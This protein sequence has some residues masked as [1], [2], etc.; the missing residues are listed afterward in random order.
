VECTL[1]C[2]GCWCRGRC[3]RALPPDEQPRLDR[4]FSL[5]LDDAAPLEVEFARK[6]IPGLTSD[7]K[8]PRDPGR[9]HPARGVHG[10]APHVVDELLEPDDARDGRTDVHSD[11]NLETRAIRLTVSPEL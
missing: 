11:P 4:A 8:P 9:L 2:H 6:P 3:R 7:L 10:V 1:D 5:D